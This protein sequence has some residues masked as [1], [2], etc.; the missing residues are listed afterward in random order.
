MADGVIGARA[1]NAGMPTSTA[2]PPGAMASTHQHGRLL[3]ADGVEGI[4]GAEAAG[5][6]LHAL[7]HVLG[8]G[9]DGVGGA[10]LARRSPSLLSSRSQA[11]MVLGAGELGALHDVE[12]DAAAADHQH[13]SSRPP[14]WRGG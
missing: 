3:A 6:L 10:E 1:E 11:M 2:W 9:V 8:L 5:Q 12:A 14:R 7:H 13:A 4:V